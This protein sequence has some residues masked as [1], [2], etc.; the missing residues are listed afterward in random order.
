MVQS[1]DDTAGA[2]IDDR[3]LLVVG[4]DDGHLRALEW[5]AEAKADVVL[6]GLFTL[7]QWMWDAI[8][9]DGDGNASTANTCNVNME[10]WIMQ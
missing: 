6:A 10:H 4:V 7:G 5:N 9:L 8:T 3:V 2:R 1:L